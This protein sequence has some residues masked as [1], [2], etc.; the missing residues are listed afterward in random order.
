MGIGHAE[1][2]AALL[3]RLETEF[4]WQFALVRPPSQ[5]QDAFDG[6]PEIFAITFES[7]IFPEGENG[8]FEI[9]IANGKLILKRWA[10][11]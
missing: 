11:V 4:P 8:D 5:I 2:T 6:S 7:T 1:V 9:V 10:D 3:A